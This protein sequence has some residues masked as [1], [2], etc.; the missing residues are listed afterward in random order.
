[1]NI[2]NPKILD[3]SIRD[4]ALCLS[5]NQ[6]ADLLLYALGNLPQDTGSRSVFE[7]AI[8]SVLQVTSLSA[9]NT[10]RARILRA[11]RR[12]SAG[13]QVAAQEDLQAALVA[14]PDNPEAK[15]LLHNRSVSVEKLLSPVLPSS[16][17]R[18]SDEIWR[19]IALWLPRKDLKTLLFVPNALSRVAGQLL[20]RKLDLHLSVPP[21]EDTITNPGIIPSYAR[22]TADILS[23]VIV[24]PSFGGFVRTLRVYSYAVGKDDSMAFQ[25][26]MLANALHKLVNLRNV[27][28]SALSEN[29]MPLLRLF[30]HSSVRL[31]GLA[32][33]CPDAPVDLSA[34]EYKTL[35]H[36]S[37]STREGNPSTTTGFIAQNRSLRTVS[38]HNMSWIF[39][40]DA[41]SLR[42]LT[43]ISFSGHFP[44][45]SPAFA[46]ILMHGRQLDSLNLTCTLECLPAAQFRANP[47]SLPFLRHFGLTV[48]GATRRGGS[49]DL[50]PAVAAFLRERTELK[51]LVLVVREEADQRTCGFDA[52][53]WGILPSLGRLRALT[54]SYPRDLAASLAA[55]LVPRSVRS[56]TLDYVSAPRDPMPFLDQLRAGVPSTLRYVGLPDFASRTPRVIVERGFPMVQVVRLGTSHWQAVRSMEGGSITDVIPSPAKSAGAVREWL[57]WLGCEDAVREVEL[58]HFF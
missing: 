11:K 36:L 15:A 39:P 23:R 56:F 33:I 48:C 38:L 27:Y 16:K 50:F 5:D 14:E 55:W 44:A 12:I 34:F 8:H 29:T 18:F 43:S 19:E 57:E 41:L 26:G 47:D 13:Y 32:L 40:S 1:M 9:H 37:Y 24:D 31:R 21:D 53:V 42:N 22:R 35:H 4:V 54:I 49:T 20:F 17:G 3:A 52:A 25:I 58:D 2:F 28:I 7:N 46:D 51:S 30:Q 6:K 10:A 45:N